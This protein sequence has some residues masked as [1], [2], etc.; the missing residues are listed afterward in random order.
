MTRSRTEN[1]FRNII[2]SL[3]SNLSSIIIGIVSRFIFISILGSEY[4]G[5]NGLFTNVISILGIVELGIGNAIIF[6][7][8]KPVA[9]NDNEK[10]KSLMKFY[11]KSYNIIALVVAIIG[12]LLVPFLN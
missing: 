4:L 12:I 1:S 8:Y 5:L 6:N 10:I 3:F 2:A 11:K 9:D 7:L